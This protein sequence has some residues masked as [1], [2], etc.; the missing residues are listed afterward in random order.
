MLELSGAR[1]SD[2]DVPPSHEVEWECRFAGLARW[3]GCERCV[4]FLPVGDASDC[5][6]SAA[7]RQKKKS[8]GPEGVRAR[9]VEGPK[10]RAFFP[11]LSFFS[12]SLGAS[13]NSPRAQT[14]TF[15]GPSFSKKHHQNSTKRTPQE[16]EERK[17]WREREKKSEILDSPPFGAPPFGAPLFA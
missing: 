4:T 14:C 12:L 17:L 10:F 5:L 16:R 15:Q 11:F 2:G 1:G 7:C 9:R 8:E 3:A 13:H 6:L